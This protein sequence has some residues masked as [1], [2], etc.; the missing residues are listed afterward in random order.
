MHLMEDSSAKIREALQKLLSAK[1][2]SGN[3]IFKVP[4]PEV[5]NRFLSAEQALVYG[6]VPSS[7]RRFSV[8]FLIGAAENNTQG[9]FS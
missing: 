1:F 5:P 4:R 3:T 9:R 8:F 7:Q 6:L 2:S